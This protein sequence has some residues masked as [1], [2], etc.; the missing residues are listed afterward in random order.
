MKNNMDRNDEI[1]EKVY[2]EE[3]EDWEKK[4]KRNHIKF[5]ILTILFYVAMCFFKWAIIVMLWRTFGSAI[6]FIFYA[7]FETTLIKLMYRIGTNIIGE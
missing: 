4:N 5:M 3:I 7:V 1:N 6:G 2:T